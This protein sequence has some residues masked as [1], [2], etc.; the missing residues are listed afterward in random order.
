[1]TTIISWNLLRLTGASLGDVAAL[2]RRERPD[3]LLMQ[4]ATEAMN[5][6]PDLVG[7]WYRREPLPGRIHGL[8]A[9]SPSPL[10]PPAIVPLPPGAMYR[11]IGQV[12]DLGAFAVANVHLSH[13]QFL[14]R[15]QLRRLSE[16]L[17]ERAAILGDY[18]LVGPT[19]L[20]GFRDVGPRE[21][22]H[23]AAEVVP[24]RLDRC[25]VRGLACTGRRRPG[26]GGIGPSPDPRRAAGRGA[27]GT[28]HLAPARRGPDRRPPA[29][30]GAG[31]IRFGGRGVA[32]E[33]GAAFLRTSIRQGTRPLHPT[34]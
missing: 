7:G 24:L 13:G 4:E 12:L 2:I 25:L 16:A 21:P 5:A 9:W 15:R 18:N 3:L 30:R 17:P 1:M 10:P 28:T 20:P 8:A 31:L 27:G 14:N 19:L 22:T 29:G 33:E 32:P 23:A 34:L 26:P 11:R 6:L